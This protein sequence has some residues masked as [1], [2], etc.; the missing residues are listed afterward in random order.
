VGDVTW[1]DDQRFE[2]RGTRFVAATAVTGYEDGQL[3]IV[4][5][6]DLVRRYERLFRDERPEHIVELGI[7]DG[8]STALTALAADP[9]LFLAVDL[10]PE[11]PPLLAATIE[12]HA[13]DDVL[14]TRFGLDQGDRAALTE[15]VDEHLPAGGFDLVIDDASHILGPTRTSFEV[16]FPRLRPGG[17]YVIEDWSAD[18][19]VAGYLQRVVPDADEFDA[20]LGPVIQLVNSLNTPGTVLDEALTAEL[21]RTAALAADSDVAA[22]NVFEQ[23]VHA[24]GRADLGTLPTGGPSRPLAD[25]AVELTMVGATSTGVI[26]EVTSN[27]EWLTARRGDAPLDPDGFRL[28]DAWT[29]PFRYLAS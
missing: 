26:S 5:P 20:R 4:K 8:G 9:K 3:V 24:A 13:L 15:F 29:D 19:I 16:L 17:L 22:E 12:R 18:C 28:A 23:I 27:S 21:V 7:K 2:V 14:V 11:I 6:P 1:I 25:L 10:E